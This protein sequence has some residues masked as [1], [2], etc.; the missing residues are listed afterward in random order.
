M[1][2]TGSE[3]PF[4]T[5]E[6]VPPKRPQGF[7]AELLDAITARTLLLVIGVL[8]IQLGFV[9][10]YVG[11]FHHPVPHQVPVAVVAPTQIS[12]HIV[13]ELSGL[14]GQPLSATAV[15][16]EAAGL[17]LLRHGST[18]GVFIVNPAGKTDSLLLASGG[19]AA[20]STAVEDVF[21]QVEAAEH[22]TLT[23][24]DAVPAQP[25]DTRGLSGFY[26]VVG[27]L[28]GGYLVA[29]L[30]GIAK[31]ARPAT[32][33]RAIHRLIVLVPY[34][35]VS[36]LGGAIIV[37]PVLGALT[38]HFMALWWLGAFLVF[39]AAAVTMAFQVLLGVFGVGLTLIV[40]VVLG[41]PSSGGAYQASLLPPFWR[42]IGSSIPNGAGV[43]A[44][45]RIVYFGSYDVVGNLLVIAIYTVAGT[46]I[47]ITGASVLARRAAAGRSDVSAVV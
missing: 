13:T 46:A 40:F 1:T 11:A 21:A 15:P 20:V 19:G 5:A 14:H 18:S 22:R 4:E 44:I 29:A 38:G 25:G 3:V 36:G 33:R 43:E 37:G 27:W 47:A 8:L 26:L 2:S 32:T 7:V 12:G 17:A 31:G 23:V 6:S 35:I 42:A 28:V 45:R 16:S 34:A 24:T 30:L 9:L 41:N 10:S 39:C